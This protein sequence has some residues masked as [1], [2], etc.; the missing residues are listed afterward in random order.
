MDRQFS[1]QIKVTASTKISKVSLILASAGSGVASVGFWDSYTKVNQNGSNATG[2]YSSGSNWVD[3]VWASGNPVL[4]GDC[5][6]RVEQVSGVGGDV[7]FGW[8]SGG[9]L[10][11]G[12]AYGMYE[13]AGL[14]SQNTD[15]SMKVYKLS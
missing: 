2:N 14:Y 8:A 13:N 4:T 9:T 12:E 6:M 1:Q 5:Y 3:F 11:E 15:F 7:G 10:Y